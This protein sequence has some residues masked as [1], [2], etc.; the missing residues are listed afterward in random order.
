MTGFEDQVRQALR[1][2]PAVEGPDDVV[3]AAA[4]DRRRRRHAM[5]LRAGAL[6]LVMALVGGGLVLR[7]GEGSGDLSVAAPTV[8]S[9]TWRSLPPSPLPPRFQQQ[10]V[11]AGR[12]LV[13]AGGCRGMPDDCRTR[14]AAAY[15]PA[16]HTWRRIADLPAGGDGVLVAAG[17]QVILVSGQ[18]SPRSWVWSPDN[19]RWRP[20]GPVPLAGVASSGTYLTWTGTEV[21]AVGQFGAGD[22]EDGSRGGSSG[23]VARL[24]LASGRWR[25]GAAAPPMPIFGDAVWTGSELIVAGVLSASGTS[26]GRGVAVAYDPVADRWRQLPDPPLGPFGSAVGWSGTEL[27]VAGF[28]TPPSAGEKAPLAAG[29]HRAAALDP[30]TGRWRELPDAPVPVRGQDR[31]REPVAGGRLVL[32]GPEG[33]LVTLN[34]TNNEWS[35]GS[36]PPLVRLD[37]PLVWTG[38]E[39]VIWG[40]GTDEQLGQG[41]SSCCTPVA[42]G[43]ATS[44]P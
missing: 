24:D 2:V 35:V 40:G 32:R 34:P 33:Q 13:V 29:R 38:G 41:S 5:G 42:G 30:T 10:A 39:L 37:A 18:S 28:D 19:D 31:Y 16:A 15:D 36:A 20:L 1:A 43:E 14:D 26:T 12:E 25:T 6:G 17:D 44:L 23:P 9:G 3:V 4:V 21:L 8:S 7:S 11:W 22:G 27:V